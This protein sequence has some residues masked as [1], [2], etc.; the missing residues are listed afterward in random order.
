MKI[1]LKEVLMNKDQVEHIRAE[2]DVM[3]V[4]DKQWIVTLYYTFQDDENLYMI[5]EFC[6][7]GD[8]MG[9]LDPKRYLFRRRQLNFSF[10]R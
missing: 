1:M 6:S 10:L 2:R 9:L 8:M 5:M 7:G 3:T 4:A